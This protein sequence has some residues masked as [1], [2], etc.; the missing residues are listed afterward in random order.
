MAY[1]AGTTAANTAAAVAAAEARRRLHEEE[2][3]MT[4]Y[5]PGDLDNDWEFKIVRANTN[6]FRK[7]EVLRKLVE[8]EARA[9][10]IMLEKFD[11]SRVRFK[12]PAS[13]RSGDAALPAGVDPYRTH[14]GLSPGRYAALLLVVIFGVTLVLLGAITALVLAAIRLF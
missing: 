1:I 5:A 13:A 7:P 6:A 12:R 2:E 14:Y 4:R 11:D 8:E 9:G 3:D 10:W